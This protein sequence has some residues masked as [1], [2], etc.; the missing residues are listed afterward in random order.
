MKRVCLVGAAGHGKTTLMVELIAEFLGRGLTVGSI[1]HS[2]HAHE[3]D[4][5]GKDSHRHRTAG[6]RPAGIITDRL[7]GV[8]VPLSPD[9]DP[10]AR[11]EPLFAGCD[12]VLIEGFKNGP[13]PKV[14]VFR[15]AAGGRPLAVDDETIRAVIS[16]DPLRVPAPVWPRSNLPDLA[17]RL[18]EMV[19]GLS[20]TRT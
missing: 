11:I 3:L 13:Y 19:E 14:E 12:L 15:S 5:P 20:R 1:K 6:A 2:G 9:D 18:L 10:F 16:D 17:A 8:F 7:A 4:E